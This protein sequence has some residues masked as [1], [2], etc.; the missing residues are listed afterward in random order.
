M[1][2]CVLEQLLRTSAPHSYDV[3]GNIKMVSTWSKTLSTSFK[4]LCFLY[5]YYYG[6]GLVPF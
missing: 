6:P 4:K 3:L 5:V 1:I 2:P